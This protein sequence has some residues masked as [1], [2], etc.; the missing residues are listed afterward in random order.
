[1]PLSAAPPI[2]CFLALFGIGALLFSPLA[3][4]QE[5]N[6]IFPVVPRELRQRLSRA[7]AALDEE[8]YSDAVGEIGEVLNS[9]GRGDFFLGNPG[10]T[11]AQLSLKTQALSL[12]GSMPAK[13]RKMYELQYGADAKAALEAALNASDLAQL[14]EV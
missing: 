11:D 9:T 3:A 13:G 5:V 7:Q 10:S 6:N 2:V 8:R 4:G 14:S 12:L 1:M